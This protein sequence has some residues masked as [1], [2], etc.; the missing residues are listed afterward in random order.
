[1]LWRARVCTDEAAASQRALGTTA[2]AVAD[3]AWL[4]AVLLLIGAYL[5]RIGYRLIVLQQ[6]YLLR[7]HQAAELGLGQQLLQSVHRTNGFANAPSEQSHLQQ[8]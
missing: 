4:L 1:M 5:E 2:T 7:L 8:L 3:L 6:N